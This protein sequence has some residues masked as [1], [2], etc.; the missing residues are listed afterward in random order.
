[1]ADSDRIRALLTR[2]NRC[3]TTGGARTRLLSGVLVCGRCQRPLVGRSQRG[4]P[5]YVCNRDTGGCGGLSITGEATDEHVRDLVLRA[6]NSPEMVA[7]LQ[8][9]DQ[10]EP[11]LH[12]RIRADEDELEA[13]AADHGNGEISRAEWKAA[14]VPVAARLAAARER[15]TSSTQTTVLDGF[16]GT[17]QEMLPRWEASNVSQHRAVVTAVLD[18]VIVR[19]ATVLGRNRVDSDRLDPVWRG[20]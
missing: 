17:Y 4:K 15:L 16:V 5:I 11:D 8:Q 7:R 6:L 10:P 14:R 18:K 2:P 19:S 1:V 12:A 20:G 3:S 9:R 13:L